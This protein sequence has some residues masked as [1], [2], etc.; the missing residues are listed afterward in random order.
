MEYTTLVRTAL[1]S[2][3]LVFCPL[4]RAVT[5]DISPSQG[6]LP[7]SPALFGKNHGISDDTARPTSDSAITLMLDAGVRILRLNDGNN[8]TKYNWRKKLS[9]HP[10]WYNNV[11]HHDWDYSAQQLQ[12]RLPGVMGFYGLQLLGWVAKTDSFNFDAD[13][14]NQ[15]K[16]WRGVAQNLAGGGVVAPSGTVQV[17]SSGVST[18]NWGKATTDGDP[19]K[20]LERWPADSTV[21]ILG[22]WFNA[23]GLGLDP[24]R[25]QYWNMDNEPDL[26]GSTHNDVVK[27]PIPLDTFIARHVAVAIKAR[28]AF[29]DIRMVG[30]V[31]SNDWY[32]WNWNGGGVI[33]SNVLYNP[34]EYFIK[35]IGAEEHRTGQRLLDVFD[36]HIYP[37]YND[38]NKLAEMLQFHRVFFDTTYAWPSSN[39]INTYIGK[40]GQPYPQ[41]TFLRVQRWMEKYL[42]P[43]RGKLGM[44]EFG[45]IGL[46]DT[47]SGG[48]AVVSACAVLYASMLG[49]FADHG[50]E[51]FTPWSWYKGM[52][53][54]LHLFSTYSRNLR[55]K[56]V[57]SLDTLVSSYASLNNAGDSLTVILVNRSRTVQNII[58]NVGTFAVR[59][60]SANAFQLAN[61]TGE[62]FHSKTDNA[63][64]AISIPVT[65]NSLTQD[66]PALSV[67]AVILSTATPIATAANT[68]V[69]SPAARVSSAWSVYPRGNALSL[70]LQDASAHVVKLLDLRGHEVRLWRSSAQREVSLPLEG[71]KNGRYLVEVQGLGSQAIALVR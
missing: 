22:H 62:T 6:Q 44:S 1:L 53:E 15:S 20:Y 68:P 9:S 13:G 36:L 32:W 10:D 42:G 58:L 57:S 63:L 51:V 29:P 56:S 8:N 60:T 17:S 24:Q 64:Q 70:T 66:L 41:Y 7:I 69:L 61:L 71:V 27:S 2:L 65:T 11:Y 28:E 3:P 47:T 14:F 52:Y 5:I 34:M 31:F 21:G 45:A 67:T 38:T 39:G 35:K 12:S 30:P 37:E 54:S 19:N 33:D 40:W 23:G 48:C 59:E 50:V 46:G 49:T 25:F 18:V 55:V 4:A 16:W 43:G 26:W